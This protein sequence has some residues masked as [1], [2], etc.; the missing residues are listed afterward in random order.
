[1]AVAES[2]LRASLCAPALETRHRHSPCVTLQVDKYIQELDTELNQFEAVHSVAGDSR[3]KQR[4]DSHVHKH[5]LHPCY[6]HC[7]IVV[8]VSFLVPGPVTTTLSLS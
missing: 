4:L 3:R 2:L 8:T 1:M 7:P 5:T 6:S